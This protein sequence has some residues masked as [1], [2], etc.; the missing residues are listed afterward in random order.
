MCGNMT[1]HEQPEYSQYV[2]YVM[3]QVFIDLFISLA[4][5]RMRLFNPTLP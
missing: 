4:E 2:H 3:P 5:H 1:G